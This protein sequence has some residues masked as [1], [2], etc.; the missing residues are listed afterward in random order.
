MTKR[1]ITPEDLLELCFVSDPQI[2]PDGLDV[3]FV[4]SKVNEKNSYNPQIHSV[5]TKTKKVRQL[6]RG[7]KGCGSPRWSPSGDRLAFI[8]GRDGAG[9]Q[10]YILPMSGGEAEAV[11][12]LAEGSVRNL[13]WSPDGMKIAFEFRDT[14]PDRT[15]S[16]TKLRKEQGLSTPA[17]KITSLWYR[18]DGDGYFGQQ[19]YKIYLLDLES[20]EVCPL[21]AESQIDSYSFDWLP[22]SSGLIVSHSV[23]DEPLLKRP[24]DQLFLVGLDGSAQQ[25]GDLNLGSKYNVTVSP[26]GQKIAFLGSESQDDPW[27]THNIHLFTVNRDGSGLRDLSAETDY[28]LDAASLSDCG[29]GSGGTCQWLP[30]GKGIR[31]MVSWHGEAHLAEFEIDSGQIE[32]LTK[33]EFVYGVGNMSRDGQTMAMT[34]A[35]WNQPAEVGVFNGG[36]YVHLTEFNNE[37]L[38]RIELSQ[39]ECHWLDST[40]GVKVQ[41]WHMKPVGELSSDSAVIEIHGGPHTQYSVAFFHE[42]QVLCAQGYHVLFSNPRGSKGYGQDFCAAIK[43]NWGEKDWEDVQ[44]LTQF[45]KALP[46][47]NSERIGIMGGSYGGYMTNWAI[48]HSHDYKAAITD[49]CV[50]NW[51]SMAG[52]SDFPM[53]SEDYFGGSA[54]G[55][56]DQIEK[57]WQQSPISYFKN[58]KTPT[59]IIH[60]EGDLRCNVEQSEQVF[61]ALY[62]QGIE[63]EF[64]RYPVETSHGM[65]RNGPPDLRLHRLHEILSWWKRQLRS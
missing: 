29:A 47:V 8:S 22:D 31:V 7:E 50:S 28:C 55:P 15:S 56:Y 43:G 1:T 5:N 45:A 21:Y 58:V 24:N 36:E 37:L 53:N 17:W 48:G 23:L 27:G 46:E 41:S 39:P 9:A 52:N 62:A 18:L 14:H 63:T 4:K 3:A 65:S 51:L 59:L 6:T 32:F 34:R 35:S 64:V 60:S 54:W 26:C 44:T 57:L 16:A 33:G 49:R 25:I 20:G 19:R 40:D 10:I 61:H 42:F 2:S 11:T 30:D 12:S 38:S 13:R